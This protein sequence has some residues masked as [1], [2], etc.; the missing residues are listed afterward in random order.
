MQVVGAVGSVLALAILGASIFLRLTTQVGEG[1]ALAST[2]PLVVERA[3]RMVHRLSASSVGLLA[4]LAVGLCWRRPAAAVARRPT[5]GIVAA[6]VVLAVI[7]PLTPGYRYASVTVANVVVGT[8]LLASFWWLRET[9][10]TVR[11]RHRPVHPL[12]I[13]TFVVFFLHVGLGAAA[14]ALEM[15]GIHWIAFLHVGTAMLTS[16]L[17]GAI[18]W[19]RREHKPLVRLVSAMAALLVAQ[20]ALGVLLLWIGG[21]PPGLGLVHAMLSPLLVA[22]LVSLARRDSLERLDVPLKDSR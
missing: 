7:G 19:D 9:L 1:G 11:T 18:L 6:T 12:L 21:R 10:A 20:L 13:A 2:L 8:I 16:M 14:S 4:L 5:I 22:G 17:I 3:V 15:R